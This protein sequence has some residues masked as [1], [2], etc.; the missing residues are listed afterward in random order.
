MCDKSNVTLTYLV[1]HFLLNKLT[2]HDTTH[3]GGIDDMAL[4]L[5]KRF[6]VKS[7]LINHGFI[8]HDNIYIYLLKH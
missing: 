3:L 8:S 1:G 6:N 7:K 4:Q 5:A 2:C